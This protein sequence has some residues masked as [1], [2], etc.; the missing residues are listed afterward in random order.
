MGGSIEMAQP[1]WKIVWQLFKK[2]NINL[3]YNPATPLFGRQ[4]REMK[5][6]VSTKTCM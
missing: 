4:P 6:H 3:L 1:Y 2:L 5:T